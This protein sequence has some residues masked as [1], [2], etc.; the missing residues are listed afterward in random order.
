MYIYNAFVVRNGKLNLEE[1][2]IKNIPPRHVV[3]KVHSIGVNRADILVTKGKYVSSEETRVVPG[4]EFSGVVVESR[5][6]KRTFSSGERVC[7]LT[8]SGAF[9]EMICIHEDLLMKLPVS[10]SGEISF[11][12]AASIPESWGTAYFNLVMNGKI[13]KGE[14]VLIHSAGGG[15]GL[16]AIQIAQ[17]IGASVV[18][19]CGTPEKIEKISELG[20][21]FVYNYKERSLE[22]LGGEYGNAINLIL[23]TIGGAA[24]EA[25]LELL[26]LNG[27][28]LLIGLLGG[29]GGNID[30]GQ[31]LKKNGTIIARTLRSQ[32]LGVKHE[33]CR[34]IE[35][36][37][38]PG[39][40]SKEFKVF[41]DEIFP[42]LE[43]ESAFSHILS[44]RNFGNVV[45]SVQ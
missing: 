16:A 13:E 30:L 4:L 17:N 29:A 24:L 8:A 7:G 6:T 42:F 26:S 1:L 2:S 10:L 32:S 44:N 41:R 27:R 12:D 45:L 39:I 40:V 34:Y 23:D 11:V 5:E 14:R 15:V 9:A 21:S 28:L 18:A 43:I 35:S 20:V 3:V 22:S 37:V 36:C 38:L 19:S 33:I 25:H 31:L